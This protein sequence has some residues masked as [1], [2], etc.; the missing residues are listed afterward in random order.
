M[1]NGTT[2]EDTRPANGED[3]V[4]GR[5]PL[6]R[7][8]GHFLGTMVS[9]F[10]VLIPLL[11]TIFILQFVFVNLDAVFRGE[12]GLLSRTPLDF[13]GVGV[14]VLVVVLYGMGLIVS[15]RVGR[16]RVVKWQGA[17]LSRIPIV[18]SIYGVAQQATEALAASSTGHRFSRVVFLE[19]PREGYLALGFV[20]GHCHLPVQEETLIVVYIPTVPNPTSGNLAFVPEREV[21]ETDMSVE[22]AMKVVFSGGIV[23]PETMGTNMGTR[24]GLSESRPSEEKVPSS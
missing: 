23:L 18:K 6:Q 22:D 19:W 3:Q 12:G 20:T 17:V 10:I 5:T 2:D 16:R 14:I 21:I 13:P 4:P 9:G 8:E 7:L 1:V 24:R 11:V 15:S